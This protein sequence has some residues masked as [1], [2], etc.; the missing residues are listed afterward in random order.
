MMEDPHAAHCVGGDLACCTLGATQGH[1]RNFAR[2]AP[3]GGA[4]AGSKPV[5]RRVSVACAKSL[6]R[7]GRQSGCGKTR[8]QSRRGTTTSRSTDCRLANT[9]NSDGASGYLSHAWRSPARLRGGRPGQRAFG[10]GNPCCRPADE[11]RHRA[12]GG[13]RTQSRFQLQ[14]S[15]ARPVDAS[16]GCRAAPGTA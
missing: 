15:A 4:G 11:G 5:A 14:G 7:H 10:V 2:T 12:I 16:D 9:G 1:K 6:P 3:A 13:C 8:M